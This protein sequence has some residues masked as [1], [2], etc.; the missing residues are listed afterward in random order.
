VPAAAAPPAPSPVEP[1]VRQKPAEPVAPKP[2]AAEISTTTLFEPHLTMGDEAESGSFLSRIPIPV[3]IGL[4][5]LLLAAALYFV[6][7]KGQAPVA[8]A[9]VA[10]GEQG[11][12][13]EWAGDA[14]GSRRG[15][16]LTLYRPSVGMTDYQMQFSGQIESK[17][18][19]WVFREADTKN[20]YAMKIENLRPGAMAIS[21]FAV[22]EGRE[23]SDSQKPLGIDARPGATYRVSWMYRARGSLFTSP[24]SRSISGPTTG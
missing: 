3:K 1:V 18:L 5:I 17:A 20:Y 13:T 8:S 22:V 2:A 9:P 11:W 7:G 14:V 15:R 6:L 19:G 24:M 23:S 10:V 16:Q 4:A 12:S 21:H